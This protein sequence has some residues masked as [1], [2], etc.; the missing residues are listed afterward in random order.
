MIPMKVDVENLIKFFVLEKIGETFLLVI[1]DDHDKV[2]T[3]GHFTN[4]NDAQSA[5]NL[6]FTLKLRCGLTSKARNKSA[7][8]A[9]DFIEDF[10]STIANIFPV[11]DSVSPSEMHK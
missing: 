6:L 3:A 8:R 2:Q 4:L 11:E 9:D 10:K 1:T 7:V 5:L